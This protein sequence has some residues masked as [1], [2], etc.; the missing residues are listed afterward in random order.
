MVRARNPAP[1]RGGGARGGGGAAAARGP[2]ASAPPPPAIV[3]GSAGDGAGGVG[4]GGPVGVAAAGVRGVRHDRPRARPGQQPVDRDIRRLQAD[5]N[6]LSF[7][8]VS[9]ARLVREIQSQFT[10]ENIRWAQEALLLFQSAAEEYLMYL[11][12]DAYLGTHHRNRVTLSTQDVR[13]VRRLRQPHC[14]NETR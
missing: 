9:F 7:A 10:E 5:H 6:Y 3:D 2:G 12:A 1:K 8:K 11:F 4:A 13:L 14:W